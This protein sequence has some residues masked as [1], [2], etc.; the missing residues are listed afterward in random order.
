M[1]SLVWLSSSSDVDVMAHGL[2]KYHFFG[3]EVWITTTHVSLLLVMMILIGF[4]IA[5]GRGKAGQYGGRH[6]GAECEEVL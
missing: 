5:A 4:S 2:L 1:G 3:H 6:H